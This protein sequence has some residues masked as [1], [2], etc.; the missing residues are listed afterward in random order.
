M[1]KALKIDYGMTDVKLID[2]I[3]KDEQTILTRLK[4]M[5][6]HKIQREA[7]IKI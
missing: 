2:L 3:F 1:L 6:I 4:R 5:H 7:A